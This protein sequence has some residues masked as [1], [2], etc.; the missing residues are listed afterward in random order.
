M[1][2]ATRRSLK[3][4]FSLIESMVALTVLSVGLLGAAAMLLDSLRIHSGALQRLAA[5]Q[6]VRDMADRIRA[7]AQGR[8]HYDTRSAAPGPVSCV[9]APGCDVAQVARQDRSHFVAAAA[10]LFARHEFIASVSFEPAT[11]PAATDRYLIVLRWQDARA[12]PGDLQSVA[13]QVLA[14][15]PV[16]G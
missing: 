4:G 12:A 7:N 15:P 9:D 2:R 13:L 1:I 5:T 6:L 8:A 10:S 14:Q 11:G 3:R 16:A